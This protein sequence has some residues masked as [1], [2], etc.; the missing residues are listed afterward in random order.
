MVTPLATYSLPVADLKA[1]V[2]ALPEIADWPEAAG[3]FSTKAEKV[4]L[5]W[6]LPVFACRA[7][8]GDPSTMA[9][10]AAAVACLQCSIIL[11]DDVLDQ[12]PRGAHHLLGEGRA[13]NLGLA[14]Q[15]AALALIGRIDVEPCYRAAAM[16]A[17]AGAAVKTAW[18][19]ELDVQNLQGESN[20]WRVVETKSTPFYGV[21]LQLGALL[22]GARPDVAQGLHDAGVVLGRMI[23]IYDDL[24]DILAAPA[25]PDWG[26]GRNNLLLLYAS[27]TAHAGRARLAELRSQVA[28]PAALREAQQILASCGAVSYAVYLLVKQHEAALRLVRSLR[29]P[30]PL[31]ILGLFEQQVQPLA[32][33]L[34]R[35]GLVAPMELSETR[36]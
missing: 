24:D 26:E 9:P 6:Q 13:A 15:A 5:D 17:L 20:Y 8:G 7:V 30:D 11:V 35:L 36:K 28:D 19:Q 27:S 1:A 16:A 21:G 23:Q 18:G 12:D 29:L 33:W 25:N 31:P 34:R 3:V 2:L 4:R 22:A 10:A 14:F 32:G